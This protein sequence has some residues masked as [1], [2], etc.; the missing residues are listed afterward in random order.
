MQIIRVS[1]LPMYADC[2]RRGAARAFRALVADA[3]FKLR[4][5]CNGIGAAIG[6]ATHAAAAYMLTEKMKSGECGNATEAEQRGLEALGTEAK[7][8][9]L[10]FDEVSPNLNT[11]QKQVVRLAKAYR[12][13]VA[14]LIHPLHVEE[15]LEAD[16]GEIRLSGQIDVD[17]TGVRDLKTGRVKRV[18]AAQYGGYSLLMR[19]HGRDVK[20]CTEDYLPRV[21]LS[22]EQPPAQQISYDI[23]LAEQEA[24]AVL[25]KIERDLSEFRETGNPHAFL[26]NPSSMLCSEKYCPAHSTSFCQLSMRK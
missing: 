24:V 26:A 6:T 1:M 7:E 25:K 13:G 10:T 15:R 19:S 2:S 4:G 21:A 5:T 12:S 3:G 18:N 22:K 20:T 9:S 16:T 17:D 23:A 11:A 14:P 8:N